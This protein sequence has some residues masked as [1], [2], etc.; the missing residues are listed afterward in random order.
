MSIQSANKSVI[1]KA[2]EVS[3]KYIVLLHHMQKNPSESIEIDMGYEILGL[4]EACAELA[5][6][7]TKKK[8]GKK[9]VK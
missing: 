1:A 5:A 7:R 6:A 8:Q 2:E 3:R 4:V 9:A